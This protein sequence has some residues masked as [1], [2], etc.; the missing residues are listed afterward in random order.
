M[1]LAILGSEAGSR[2]GFLGGG[3][4]QTRHETAALLLYSG[5]LHSFEFGLAVALC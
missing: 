4:L 1:M 2:Q 3:Q 5:E